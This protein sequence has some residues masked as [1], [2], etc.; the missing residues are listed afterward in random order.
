LSL[1]APQKWGPYGNRRPFPE[2]YLAYLLGSPVK[3]PSLQV[4]FI[5]LPWRKMPIPRA[6]LHS[7]FNVP[8]I[9]APFQVPS[10][11]PMERHAHLQSFIYTSCRVPS[12]GAPPSGSPHRAP[13][14]RERRSIS[15]SPFI[16]LSKSLVNE[17]PSRFTSGAPM[18][19]DACLQSLF[20]ITFIH[21]SKTAVHEPPSR[22][23]SGAPMERDAL[24]STFL[25]ITFRVPSRGASLQ[26]PLTECPY[27][28]MLHFQS[29]P[30]ICQSSR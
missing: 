1:H 10:G 12:K 29:P 19:R 4:P 16:H 24:T 28:E 13:S 22:F 26:V 27:R 21:L 14:E 7:Y 11:T 20:Y 9:L 8:G 2:T 6:L 23:P 25:Y 18:E 3:E 15:R 30:T 5:E 17:L